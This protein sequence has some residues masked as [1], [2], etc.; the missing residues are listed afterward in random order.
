MR[1]RWCVIAATD[2]PSRTRASSS[3]SGRIG[4]A[5]HDGVNAQLFRH[6]VQG[7]FLGSDLRFESHDTGSQCTYSKHVVSYRL[8]VGIQFRRQV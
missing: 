2:L 5:S 8:D 1:S 6:G 3:A 4:S 7:F